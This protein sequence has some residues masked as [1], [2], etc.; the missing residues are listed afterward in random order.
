[1]SGNE[2]G[3]GVQESIAGRGTARAKALWWRERVIAGVK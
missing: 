3:V 2:I 1:M